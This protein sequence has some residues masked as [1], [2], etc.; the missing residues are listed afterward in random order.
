MKL[1]RSYF[2]T[3]TGLYIFFRHAAVKEKYGPL[4]GSTIFVLFRKNPVTDGRVCYYL[5][6]N[7]HTRISHK[8]YS[9]VLIQTS[10]T[11]SKEVKE[12]NLSIF[13]DDGNI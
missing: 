8:K 9:L 4:A 12:S 6:N 5:I 7:L 13:R 2:S 10:S 1:V 11:T 3:T